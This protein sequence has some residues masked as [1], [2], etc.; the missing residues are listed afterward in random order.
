MPL[1]EITN[2]IWRVNN[3]YKI[4]DKNSQLITF[5]QNS[6]QNI[7]NDD[8]PRKIILKARQFGVSTN[9]II[10]QLDETMWTDNYV[11]CILAHEQDAIRKLFEIVQRAYA[12][13]PPELSV[14]LG[15]GGG[16]KYEYAFPKMG[17]KIYSDLESRGDT[18]NWLHISEVAFIRDPERIL[19]TM[20]CV[21]ING[22][23]TWE[24]T[25]N[26][27]GNLFYDKWQD[28]GLFKKFFFP[29]F[30]FP[31][32]RMQTDK[33][34]HTEEET[35]LIKY[36]KQSFGV[37]ISDEQLRF[38]RSKKHDLK[39]LFIQEY[40]EDSESCFLASGSA[41]FDLLKISELIKNLKEP[42]EVIGDTTIY[43]KHDKDKTYVIGADTAEGKNNDSS[44]G[45]VYSNDLE[46]VA[47]LRSNKLSPF[48]FANELN[49]LAKMYTSKS[50]KVPLVGVERNNHGHAVL[51][52]LKEHIK[53]L[54]LFQHKDENYG[55]LTDKITRPL[56]LDAFVDGVQNNNL[57]INDKITLMECMT[58]INNEGKMEAAPNKHDDCIIASSIAVQ[59]LLKSSKVINYKNKILI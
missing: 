6:I 41:V 27:L 15:K 38:R 2:E 1:D 26:G 37:D 17:S 52:E 21:P 20:E 54:N 50:G 22:R 18:I 19:S 5:K 49:T 35:K 29:W 11:S 36:A 23:I 32:Y 33:L 4:K 58:L 43:K 25:P 31:E 7:L 56:M 13:L 40:P 3:L 51:L 42:L 34:V 46:L 30:I 44:V 24:S 16:S 14:E 12:S 39:H 53:Y 47:T 57:K 45:H 28:P 9:E 59:L 10:K 8:S 55:W 48:E